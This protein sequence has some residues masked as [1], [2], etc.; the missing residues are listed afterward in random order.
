MDWN[1]TERD[2]TDWALRI[3]FFS[4]LEMERKGRA[5]FLVLQ[6]LDAGWLLR[7]LEA[8]A[9]HAAPFTE[10]GAHL[11]KEKKNRETSIEGR[12]GTENIVERRIEKVKDRS[13]FSSP[14]FFHWEYFDFNC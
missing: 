7:R 10:T 12:A 8:L 2:Q 1:F 11:G 13:L 9:F 14:S 4:C 3:L 5:D 6:A